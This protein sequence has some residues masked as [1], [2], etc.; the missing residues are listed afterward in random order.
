[1][2]GPILGGKWWGHIAMTNEKKKNQNKNHYVNATIMI[3]ASQL[4]FI[5]ATMLLSSLQYY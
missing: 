1:M 4:S 5:Y 3:C 2:G